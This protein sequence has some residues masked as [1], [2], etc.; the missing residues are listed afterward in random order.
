VKRNVLIS[1][2][3]LLIILAI[4]SSM[5]IHLNNVVS[6]VHIYVDKIQYLEDLGYEVLH[7]HARACSI[8]IV[9]TTSFQMFEDILKESIVV[10]PHE[11]CILEKRAV[12][13]R[14]DQR[15]WLGFLTLE[16]IYITYRMFE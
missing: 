2:A 8:E 11:G 16:R 12:I 1:I 14:E 7:G 4:G 5:I 6:D 13:F 15:M 3:F 10:F 9:Y